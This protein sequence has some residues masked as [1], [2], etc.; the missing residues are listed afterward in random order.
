MKKRDVVSFL[1]VVVSVVVLMGCAP[2]LAE[3]G[4]LSETETV[5]QRANI[6]QN[7][8]PRLIVPES[9][10]GKKPQHYVHNWDDNPVAYIPETT[11]VDDP[12]LAEEVP[13]VELLRQYPHNWDDNPVAYI[14]ETTM[15]DDLVLAEEVP[16]VEL[17]RQCPHNWD[18]NPVATI[19][20]SEMGQ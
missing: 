14:P 1:L 20:E 2:V 10:M 5:A 6:P 8:D 11:M 19:P 9:T 13:T 18:D 3:S 7:T 12:V 16:T 17:L 15:V 4:E